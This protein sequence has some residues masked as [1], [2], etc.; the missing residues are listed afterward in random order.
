[1]I[2]EAE[3]FFI[4]PKQI[5]S[6][7]TDYNYVPAWVKYLQP[8]EPMLLVPNYSQN[9]TKAETCEVVPIYFW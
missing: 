6:T 4:F 9:I 1:M 3:E 2:L 5:G 8:K 7:L